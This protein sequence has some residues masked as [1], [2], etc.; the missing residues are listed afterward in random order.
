MNNASEAAVAAMAELLV[1]SRLPIGFTPVQP[2]Q[3]TQCGKCAKVNSED[4]GDRSMVQPIEATQW[5]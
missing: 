3:C 2:K 4:P 5:G 1:N